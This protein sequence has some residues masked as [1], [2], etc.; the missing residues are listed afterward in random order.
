MRRVLPLFLPVVLLMAACGDGDSSSGAS[1]TDPADTEP[2]GTEPIGTEPADIEPASSEESGEDGFPI[3]ITHQYGETVVESMPERVAAAGLR[4][5]DSILAL[6][7]IPV[8]VQDWFG[9]QPDA[10]WPWA[11]DAL[12]GAEPVVLDPAARDYEALAAADPDLII[13]ID[14]GLT[15]EEYDLMTAIAPTIAAPDGYPDYAVP[16]RERTLLTAESLGLLDDGEA[17][18]ADVEAQIEAAAAAHPEFA[19]ATALVGLAG[20]DGQAYAYGSDDV[21]S[22]FLGELGF[23]IPETIDSQVED[24]SFYL[25]LSQ[26]NFDQLDADVLAWVGGDITAF[27]GVIAEPLYPR[28]VADEGRDLFL[29]YDPI[30]GAISFSSPLSLPFLVE[31]LVPELAL[32]VDGDEST[33]SSFGR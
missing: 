11:Q 4:D 13:A 3:T 2:S 18:V 23:S 12:G 14:A 24:G 1:S 6:G 10:V 20:V 32:A 15:P 5:Q 8:A 16:W 22:Q 25:T 21:R 7:V 29:P 27:E 28:R 17:V 19:E 9:D 31:E 26:E 33:V 30:G